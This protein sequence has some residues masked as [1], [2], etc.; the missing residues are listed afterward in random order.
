IPPLGAHRRARDRLDRRPSDHE[1]PAR[2]RVGR[3]GNPGQDPPRLRRAVVLLRRPTDLRGAAARVALADPPARAAPAT[4]RRAGSLDRAL[5]PGPGRRSGIP[6]APAAGPGPGRPRSVGSARLALGPRRYVPQRRHLLA[7]DAG[8]D[9]SGGDRSPR[10]RAA[11]GVLRSAAPRAPAGVARLRHP[12]RRAPA[13]RAAAV[14][15]AGAGRGSRAA[16]RGPRA[17]TVG[18]RAPALRVGRAHAPRPGRQDGARRRAGAGRTSHAGRRGDPR[19]V[20][21]P[22]PADRE[23]AAVRIDVWSGGAGGTYGA[24]GRHWYS[25]SGSFSGGGLMPYRTAT[26][27]RFS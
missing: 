26:N 9:L 24:G 22:S 10:A 1:R 3:R 23:D 19:A 14:A 2:A 18:R 12:R 27:P 6:G 17:R 21:G 15:P 16:S 7:Q 5:T 13:A 11:V 25:T 4:H 8:S 20:E